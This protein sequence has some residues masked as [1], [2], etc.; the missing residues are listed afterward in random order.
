MQREARVREESEALETRR[1]AVHAEA[2]TA[3]R[4]TR[5]AADAEARTRD[6]KD[7]ATAE[8]K[9]VSDELHAARVEAEA[10]RAW[11]RRQQEDLTYRMRAASVSPL[12]PPHANSPQVHNPIL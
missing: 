3:E 1:A 8:R 7:A 6:L 9:K 2:A 5:A 4:V 11:V 10:S 12:H